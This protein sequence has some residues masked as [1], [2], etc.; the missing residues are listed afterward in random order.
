MTSRAPGRHRRR[1]STQRPQSLLLLEYP[2][3][4]GP[5]RVYLN[6][7]IVANGSHLFSLGLASAGTAGGSA[8]ARGSSNGQA[9][10]RRAIRAAL[11]RDRRAFAIAL[12]ATL[13]GVAAAA[14]FGAFAPL[15]SSWM[16]GGRHG[17]AGGLPPQ[18][19]APWSAAPLGS[20]SGQAT[21][22]TPSGAGH[23][24]G[25]RATPAR[26]RR[27]RGL[28][29]RPPR[30]APA[31]PPA[32]A[33]NQHRDKSQHRDKNQHRLPL[34]VGYGQARAEGGRPVSRGQPGVRRVPGPGASRQRRHAAHRRLADRHRAARRYGDG[35][36]E[37]GRF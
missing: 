35:G 10:G 2:G 19:S 4:D 14:L 20:P 22:R 24:A 27:Q 29:A 9:G 7:G 11:L 12:S 6:S 33:R 1:L 18:A 13:A 36:P 23:P 21:P 37:R 17:A 28:P 34:L 31:R 25:R 8:Q 30:P 32:S 3:D 5:P 15:H 16:T 26:R